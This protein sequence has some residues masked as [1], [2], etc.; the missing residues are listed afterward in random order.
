MQALGQKLLLFW[1][2]HSRIINLS[3]LVLGFAFDLW[4]AKR[5][6]SFADNILL[7]T[8]LLLAGGIIVALNI[9]TLRKK[10]EAEHPTEP[11]LLLL[12]LQFCFGGLANNLLILYGKSGTLSG[13]L[14]FIFMLAGFALGNEFLKSRY[15]QLRFN[16][17]IFYFLLLTYCVIAV[18]TFITHSIGTGAFLFSC[19]VSVV[20]I[21]VFLWVLFYK[22][23]KRR[24]KQQMIE[25]S[26]ILTSI[27]LVFNVFYFL[28]IIP[29]V[30]LSLKQIGVYHSIVRSSAGEATSFAATYEQPAWYVFWRDTSST[31]T[32]VPGEEAYCF[33]AVFAPGDLST[34]VVH[35]WQKY[36][37]QSGKW[38]TQSSYIFSINGGRAEGYRG[39]SQK[40]VTPGE[41]RCNIETR[42]GQTIG[43][44]SFT[45]K[46]GNGAEL[47]ATSL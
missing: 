21:G 14:F 44:I 6:D 45:A 26:L 47:T 18:P 36:N 16:V 15:E 20:F 1:E 4:L 42:K 38:E 19:F 41:W 11:L 23:F 3:G 40:N 31:F 39:F 46:E 29:P 43:R 27:L 35:R 24:E 34:P 25:V 5:P 30:P 37:Q 8:Y 32:Y 17:A 13:S 33:S 12:L 9:R 10:M 7:I 22:V 2:K 28:N